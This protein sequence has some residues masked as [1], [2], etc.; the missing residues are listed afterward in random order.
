MAKIPDCG[1]AEEAGCSQAPERIRCWK[2]GHSYNCKYWSKA[3]KTDTDCGFMWET[4][5]LTIEKGQ[6]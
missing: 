1:Y 3:S 5:I 2:P 4:E 6:L